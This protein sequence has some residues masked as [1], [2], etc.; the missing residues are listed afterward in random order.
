MAVV[1]SFD[2]AW[3]GVVPVLEYMAFLDLYIGLLILYPVPL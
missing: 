2:R 1:R 3:S